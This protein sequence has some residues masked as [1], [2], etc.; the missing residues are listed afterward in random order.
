M[1]TRTAGLALSFALPF[2]IMGAAFALHG[3]YPFGEMLMLESDARWQLY[4]FLSSFWHQIR[5]GSLAPW[6][7][8]AGAGHDYVSLFAYFL[9]S[10][11]NILPLLAPHG[12]L[13][14]MITLVLLIKIGLAGLFTG[15]YLRYMLRESSPALPVF[16]TLYALC[17]F[18]LGYYF[19]IPSFDSVALLPLVMLG[20]N[21]LMNEEKYQLYV[22]SLA[23]AVFTNYLIGFFIC[24]F[25]VI[26]FFGQCII[27]KVNKRDFM[28]KL[29]LITAHS[30]LAVGMTAVLLIPTW[31]ALS[32]TSLQGSPFPSELVLFN[33]FFDIFGNLIAF[34]SPTVAHGLPNLYSG[35]VTVMLAGLFIFSIKVSRREKIVIAGTVVFLLVSCNINVLEYMWNGF[36]YFRGTPSRYSFLLSFMLVTMAYK[37]FIVNEKMSRRGF[38]VMG[39]SAALF[40]LAAVF[41]SQERMAIVGSAVL[42]GVYILL[43]F[44]RN[45]SSFKVKQ[46]VTAVFF[47]IILV[48]LSIGSWIGVKTNG[49]FDKD[50]YP[51]RYEQI[52]S[53]LRLRKTGGSI[54]GA[55][56][57]RTE[58]DFPRSLN[59]PFLYHYNGISFYSSTVNV[60]TAQ[61][62]HGLGLFSWDKNYSYIETTPLVN[63]FLNMRYVIKTEK[64]P[65]E[66]DV[67][68]EIAGK[69]ED[70]FLLE[71]KYY[72]PLGF[73]VKEEL[74]GYEHQGSK[75]FLLQNNLFNLA[76]RLEG[77]LFTVTNITDTNPRRMQNV[78]GDNI[79]IWDYTMPSDDMLYVYLEYDKAVRL[80]IFVNDTF[81]DYIFLPLRDISSY[82]S[83]VGSFAQGEIV[84][85]VVLEGIDI[86][87]LTGCF[88]S[89][90]FK[91]GYAQLAAQPFVLTQ[92]TETRVSGHITATEDGLLYT[93]IPAD[94]N[95]S[96]YVDGVK[97][98]IVL[99][100]NAMAAVRLSEGT[101]E[102]EFRYFN[103]SFLAGI[104]ISLF[105]LVVFIVLI[106]VKRNRLK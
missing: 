40:L 25:V 87:M 95:W 82:I 72:L 55:D 57:Y 62:M 12:F 105:S 51:Y 54:A 38:M 75:H 99:I 69:E 88:N 91:Q 29:G 65:A 76:T 43:L 21:A 50:E 23:L 42:C 32:H 60:N 7:W 104:I 6:S 77:D 44:F 96:V 15:I 28:R 49:T 56:F 45:K 100:D 14:V 27:H 37:A 5:E 34:L 90:L 24:I 48:E 19:S 26:T 10:P 81:F 94:R 8:I 4:P 102:I 46:F 1:K 22:I 16:S 39:L 103:R 84:S 47:L 52:Q 98:G 70:A 83:P 89:V 36:N 33:S 30:L 73:M 80:G 63:T 64:L 106:L 17:S 41:G 79:L 59:D 58:L 101:H 78:N 20:L 66:N 92:F 97:S 31:F 35:M 93:S 53:L 67:Y 68:W 18:T 74:A 85:F 71:N 11:L 9:A 86:T 61:F 2:T 3:V 13:P